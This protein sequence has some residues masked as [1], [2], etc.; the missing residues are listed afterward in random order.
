MVASHWLKYMISHRLSYLA[1][2]SARRLSGKNRHYEG[3]KGE[4][5]QKAREII[6]PAL[7]NGMKVSCG[8]SYP[9]LIAA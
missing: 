7:L 1:C 5:V 2:V 3:D 8:V 4:Q 6:S 9:V